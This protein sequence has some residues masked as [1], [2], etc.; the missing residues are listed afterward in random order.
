M[1]PAAVA[2]ALAVAALLS[3]CQ[4]EPDPR[5]AT[6]GDARRGGALIQSYGCGSC[7]AIPG[8]QAANGSVGPPLSSY[9]HR[10]YVAGTLPN[11]TE[12]LVL[13][14]RHPQKVHPGSAM[15]DM[16]V[17]EA[18]ARDSAAYLYAH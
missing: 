8:V 15:P 14:I 1:T 6:G 3:A 18:D 13:W 12:Q 17:S 9:S 2:A 11:S 5:H 10:T 16:G 7:H 4:A